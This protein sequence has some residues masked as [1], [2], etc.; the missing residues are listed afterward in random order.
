MTSGVLWSSLAMDRMKRLP[1]AR[2]IT[3][4]EIQAFDPFLFF[5]DDEDETGLVGGLFILPRL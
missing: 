5:L 4:K 1:V 2:S 3:R